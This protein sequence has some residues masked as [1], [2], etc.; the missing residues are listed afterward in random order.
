MKSADCDVIKDLLPSYIDKISSNSTNN[1]IEK[2][3]QTCK[4]C[5]KALNDM[6]KNTNI[7]PLHNQDKEIDYL[8]GY[9]KKKRNSIIFTIFI[10]SLILLTIVISMFKFLLDA[11]FFINIDDVN[12]VFTQKTANVETGKNKFT[13]LI[14]PLNRQSTLKCYTYAVTEGTNDKSLHIKIVGKFGKPAGSF[15]S[16]DV[17]SSITKIYLEDTNGNLKELW[18]KDTGL[19]IKDISNAYQINI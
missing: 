4:N 8:K 10:T 12:V 18:N 5:N 13:F 15:Y 3:I 9:R 17:D 2:H 6:R 14:I 16:V 11:E 19:L 7:E 1:L